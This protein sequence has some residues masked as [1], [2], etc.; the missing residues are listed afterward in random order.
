M[1]KKIIKFYFFN[2]LVKAPATTYISV[3]SKRSVQ[4]TKK[5][6]RGVHLHFFR[7]RTKRLRAVRAYLRSVDIRKHKLYTNQWVYNNPSIHT[8]FLQ[9]FYQHTLA[10]RRGAFFLWFKVKTRFYANTYKLLSTY[11][12]QG[13]LSSHLVHFFLYKNLVYQSRSKYRSAVSNLI[14]FS[15]YSYWYAMRIA[16][17]GNTL[18]KKLYFFTSTLVKKNEDVGENF[19]RSSTNWAVT[20]LMTDKLESSESRASNRHTANYSV[21][22]TEYNFNH[23]LILRKYRRHFIGLTGGLGQ[24]ELN[25]I[26][27]ELHQ[28]P[29]YAPVIELTAQCTVHFLEVRTPHMGVFALLK[30]VGP[31]CWLY[32]Y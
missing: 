29:E 5:N 24:V 10:K 27:L 3:F 2:K 15:K 25:K 11:T 9:S 12:R 18:K 16:I 19:S 6:N 26:S 21:N 13:I 17:M 7:S 20:K 32:S 31:Y 1:R 8:I 23:Y 4:Q 28:S 30:H 14:Q 22:A